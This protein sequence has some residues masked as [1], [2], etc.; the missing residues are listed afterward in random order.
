VNQVEFSEELFA[1]V[2]ADTLIVAR[3][4]RN[5][6]C[7]GKLVYPCQRSRAVLLELESTMSARLRIP[8]RNACCNT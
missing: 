2:P 1:V 3:R 7:S 4:D 6:F 5:G 8:G